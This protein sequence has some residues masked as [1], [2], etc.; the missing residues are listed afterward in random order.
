MNTKALRNYFIKDMGQGWGKSSGAQKGF[1]FIMEAS[2]FVKGG[3]I[4]DAGAGEQRFKPFFKNSTYITQEHDQ[5]IHL[6]GMDKIEYD[7]ISPIDRK[8]PLKDSCLDGILL[9]SVLE[10]LRYPEK[11]F[12]E[13]LRVLKPGGKIYISVPFIAL[14]HEVPYDF[15]RPTRFGLER[16]LFDA[17]FTKIQIK[18]SSTCVQGVISY[19]PVAVVYDLLQT[20]KNPRN[21]FFEILHTKNGYF[22]IIKKVPAFLFAGI[23]YF[24]MKLFVGLISYFINVEVYP[25]ANMPSGWFAVASK[26]GKFSKKTYESKQ[27]F[28]SKNKLK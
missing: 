18:A 6:K 7:L 26:P 1:R 15:Q 8:I 11:F 23:G 12:A 24:S 21:I 14:E 25:E 10:H 17:G 27:K 13:G 3:V 20:N 16:W 5:G 2:S 4:L 28:L 9:N 19:L 22:K